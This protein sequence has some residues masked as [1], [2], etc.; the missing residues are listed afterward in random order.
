MNNEEENPHVFHVFNPVSCKLKVSK[1]NVI[2]KDFFLVFD[3]HP[4]VWCI[5]YSTYITYIDWYCTECM[6]NIVFLECITNWLNKTITGLAFI[7]THTIF[8]HIKKRKQLLVR[9]QWVPPP[10]IVIRNFLC[11]CLQR[12]Q[13]ISPKPLKSKTMF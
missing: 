4:E 11:T 9:T 5:V 3:V 8:V 7:N 1:I 6:Q 2:K 10:I 12:L 13:C